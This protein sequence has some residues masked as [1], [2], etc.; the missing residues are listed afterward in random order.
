MQY[1]LIEES[2][3]ARPKHTARTLLT[4][5]QFASKHTA[6]TLGALRNLLFYATPRKS[7]RGPV[8]PNGLAPA[9][10]R[11]GKKVMIDE[12]KF[13]EWLDNQQRG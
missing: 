6:W 12:V 7:S 10:V 1:P 5:Q 9:I 8:P 2:L 3:Y 11:L 4:V 13:F